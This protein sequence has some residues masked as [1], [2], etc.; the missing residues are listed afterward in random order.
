[1]STP[2]RNGPGR[3]SAFTL[4][5]LLVVIFLI[6]FLAGLL[7]LLGPNLFKSEKSSRGAQ[8]LQG[9]LFIAKQQALRDR[10]PY[11]VRLLLDSDGQVRSCQ[12]IQQP[13]DFS[14][15]KVTTAPGATTL[16]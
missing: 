2:C 9:I 15:G 4:I 8:T 6:T 3:R 11:G 5:E 7:V 12:F 1:M 10:S 16:T 14:G 13:S